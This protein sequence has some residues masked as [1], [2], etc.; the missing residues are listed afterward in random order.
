MTNEKK[1]WFTR[2]VG[3]NEE[4]GLV[5]RGFNHLNEA[6]FIIEEIMESAGTHTSETARPLAKELAEKLVG[7]A[8]TTE[9][10]IVGSMADIMVYATGAIAKLGF[11]P[12]LVMEEIFKEINARTGENI[13]GKFVKDTDVVPY[14][15]DLKSCRV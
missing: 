14:K 15:P 6:S 9:E 4:R 11:S 5:A 3:W 2:I 13:D 1:D 10:L 7:N 8:D 12:S